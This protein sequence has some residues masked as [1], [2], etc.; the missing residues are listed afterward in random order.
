MRQWI[1]VARGSNKQH[2]ILNIFSHRHVNNWYTYEVNTKL[3]S[4]YAARERF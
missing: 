2:H 3:F 1:M 4:H